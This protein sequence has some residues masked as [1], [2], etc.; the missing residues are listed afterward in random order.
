M[1]QLRLAVPHRHVEPAVTQAIVCRCKTSC[2]H[3]VT[4][5]ASCPLSV[6]SWNAGLAPSGTALVALRQAAGGIRSCHIWSSPAKSVPNRTRPWAHNPYPS[7][8][9]APVGTSEGTNEQVRAEQV[10]STLP[11][12]DSLAVQTAACRLMLLSP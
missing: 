8:A 7:H 12:Q 5:A 10:A 2:P 1:G 11:N 9:L 3:C 6:L 4:K